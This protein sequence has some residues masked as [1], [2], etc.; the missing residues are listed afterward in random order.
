MTKLTQNFKYAVIMAA[1]F[2]LAG[3]S[4]KS[5]AQ[6]TIA[7]MPSSGTTLTFQ[8][9]F[10]TLSDYAENVNHNFNASSM[11]SP[12]HA[13]ISGATALAA[14]C[15]MNF[16][17]ISVSSSS[18]THVGIQA[19]NCYGPGYVPSLKSIDFPNAQ[20]IAM[21]AC[22]QCSSLTSIN[23]PNVETIE[24]WAFSMC[25]ALQSINLPRVGLIDNF[26]FYGCTALQ[27][28]NIPTVAEIRNAAF[29][30]CT[31]LETVNMSAVMIIGDKAFMDCSALQS[32]DLPEVEDIGISAF[33]NC[34]ALTTAT[35][36]KVKN[37]KTA[38]F[39]NCTNLNE[40]QMPLVETIGESAFELCEALKT[41]SACPNLQTIN[42]ATFKFCTS[43]ED[44]N[45][46]F[47]NVKTIEEQAFSHCKKLHGE[48]QLELPEVT[49][50]GKEA[51]A[52]CTYLGM[53]AG[54]FSGS[55]F[56]TS[57]K[58]P[59]VITIKER[60]FF[61]CPFMIYV[62]Y[63]VVREFG[64]DV[65]KKTHLQVVTLGK[66]FTSP[67]TITVVGN[68][69]RDIF[70]SNIRNNHVLNI[71]TNVRP[72]WNI[73][74]GICSWNGTLW[75]YIGVIGESVPCS[76]TIWAE[77][78]LME[79][80]AFLD[81]Y[82]DWIYDL[83]Q[84]R[85]DYLE[86]GINEQ[87]SPPIGNNIP[88]PPAQQGAPLKSKNNDIPTLHIKP[89]TFKNDGI[90]AYI[91]S[92]MKTNIGNNAFEE[93]LFLQE[94]KFPYI[95]SNGIGNNAFKNCYFL[96][97]V[98]L[99]TG[100]TEP[101]TINLTESVSS[102][103]SFERTDSIDLVIGEHV[104]PKPVG[105]TWNSYTWKSINFG[106][107]GI[108]EVKDDSREVKVYPNPAKDVLQVECERPVVIA[109]YDVTGREVLSQGVSGNT[110][111]KISHLPKGI[112]MMNVILDG[113]V[114]ENSKIVKQ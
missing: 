112:Y 68:P 32:I 10:N 28:A 104:L 4:V 58:L 111:I 91:T 108:K 92:P 27:T 85:A 83:K 114:I 44:I 64:A 105:K 13:V 61:N 9:V 103:R 100:Y 60:A 12:F 84:K 23:M 11:G 80:K 34:H 22:M 70:W 67:T 113:R 26:A 63:P 53:S 36:P 19:L 45:G 90:L 106:T 96:R 102:N 77:W 46:K 15:F 57:V 89:E 5:Y 94:I 74:D 62:D 33:E 17:V 1:I 55:D 21:S 82:N 73:D 79:S 54:D 31:A 59:K 76:Y 52:H 20:T 66:G 18:V 8:E 110:E 41:I 98:T 40:I 109:L 48:T 30:S 72:R 65:Y 71:H 101:T 56:F 3:N 81:E 24:A 51:F 88:I 75:N 38:A 69:F 14:G 29:Q 37:I 97:K 78:Q 7:F 35:C 47:P 87:S 49:S 50:I 25:T 107:V 93:C 16:N 86:Q 95:G 6:P 2:L 99:G 39:L 42:K 43:L